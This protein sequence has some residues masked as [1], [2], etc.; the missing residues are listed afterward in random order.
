ME[1]TFDSMVRASLSELITRVRSVKSDQNVIIDE[2]E[3]RFGKREQNFFNSNHTL[4]QFQKMLAYLRNNYPVLEGINDEQNNIMLDIKIENSEIPVLDDIRISIHGPEDFNSF[5]KQNNLNELHNTVFE[6]K[7]RISNVDV[8]DYSLIRLSASTETNVYVPEE[9]SVAGV[10]MVEINNI[11]NSTRYQKFYRLKKRYSFFITIDSNSDYR[12]RVDMTDVRQ[13]SG[14][15]LK[16]SKVKETKPRYEIEIEFLGKID[17]QYPAA[18]LNNN[19]LIAFLGTFTAAYKNTSYDF[20][21]TDNEAAIVLD[22]YLNIF[23]KNQDTSDRKKFSKKYFVGTDIRPLEHKHVVLRN[24]QTELIKQQYT[25]SVKADGE[26]TLLFLRGGDKKVYSIDS[27]LNVRIIGILSS[28]PL[29]EG[30]YYMVD[31][32]LVETKLETNVFLCFDIIYSIDRDV[33]NVMFHAQT[34]SRYDLLNKFVKKTKLSSGGVTLRAIGYKKLTSSM[35]LP[36]FMQTLDVDYETDGLIFTP[37]SKYPE[38]IMD[39]ENTRLKWKPSNMQSIDFKLK[40]DKLDNYRYNIITTST[41]PKIY[42]TLTYI[43]KKEYPTFTVKDRPEISK[44]ALQVNENGKPIFENK[45]LENGTI[46]ECVFLDGQWKIMR[47]RLDKKEPNGAIA[48]FSNWKLITDPITMAELTGTIVKERSNLVSENIKEEFKSI[49]EPEK[50]MF[51]PSVKPAKKLTFKSNK[52]ASDPVPEA[53]PAI[54]PTE[55]DYSMDTLK[56]KI[57]A[58]LKRT[59]KLEKLTPL[60]AQNRLI[61]TGEY[62]KEDLIKNKLSVAAAVKQLKEQ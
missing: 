23:Y 57:K 50:I 53:V 32:E 17:T 2:V 34:E 56:Q 9:N 46:A 58:A 59:D 3:F 60:I 33:R 55:P 49:E 30:N 11:L 10:S 35:S 14:Y 54:A 7:K 22:N 38:S 1:R 16:N 36:E 45:I 5:C 12:V 25:V 19:D 8:Q 24:G 48:V 39:K 18:I 26:R 52:A 42:A 43:S 29:P 4:V 13:S 20:L 44:I 40:I 51:V 27:S 15:S 28:E 31:G 47:L 6:S 61:S 62:T 41:G 21:M 37:A